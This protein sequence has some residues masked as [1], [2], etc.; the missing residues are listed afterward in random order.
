MALPTDLT[1]TKAMISDKVTATGLDDAQLFEAV[2]FVNLMDMISRGGVDQ[3]DSTSRGMGHSA[4]V[5]FRGM[6]VPG[7][8]VKVRC[9]WVFNGPFP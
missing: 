2:L 9:A 4:R 3:R 8:L 6:P 1:I 5:L 7:C